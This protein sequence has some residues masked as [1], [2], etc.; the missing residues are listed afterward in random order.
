MEI[1]SKMNLIRPVSLQRTSFL[2]RCLPNAQCHM[3][4]II[5]EFFISVLRSRPSFVASIWK[6]IYFYDKLT[7]I[8]KSS[9]SSLT[10]VRT[11]SKAVVTNK[12]ASIRTYLK[13]LYFFSRSRYTVLCNGIEKSLPCSKQLISRSYPEPEE[14]SP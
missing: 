4:Y 6:Y 12:L 10:N 5:F 8:L 7:E 11:Q 13:K 1:E 3:L 9:A 14:F 2:S